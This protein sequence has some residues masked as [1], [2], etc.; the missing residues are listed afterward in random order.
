MSRG[1]V[2]VGNDFNNHEN[3]SNLELGRSFVCEGRFSD[4]DSCFE[5]ELTQ[6]DSPNTLVFDNHGHLL[7]MMGQYEDAIDK[8][9]SLLNIEPDYVS[10]LFGKGI[11]FIGL[12]KLDEALSYFD[13]V[14]GHD[15][16]HAEAWYF[17]AI[18]CGNPFYHKHDPSFAKECYEKYQISRDSYI[19]KPF[20]DL[21]LEE[22]HY[23][24]KFTDFFR[25]IDRLLERENIGEFD[26]FFNDFRRLYCFN[27]DDLDKQFEIFRLFDDDIPLVDKIERLNNDKQLENKFESAGFDEDLIADLS[28]HFGGLSIEDKKILTELMGYFKTSQLSFNDIND[29]IRENVFDGDMTLDSFNKNRGYIVENRIE[30]NN[31]KLAR[32]VEK[33]INN[34]LNKKLAGNKQLESNGNNF[35]NITMENKQL[36]ANVNDLNKKVKLLIL[37]IIFILL[38]FIVLLFYI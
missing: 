22:V 7:N 17:S 19:N 10:S 31:H 23:Y 2:V 33:K 28:S 36:K 30:E 32:D 20:D 18:I 4:A 3:V 35:N 26:K 24:Y 16:R 6:S 5:A 11:S 37:L 9:D 8:F 34:E 27:E 38:V 1:V 21:S 14:T 29:L 25:L 13:K 15:K 12:N